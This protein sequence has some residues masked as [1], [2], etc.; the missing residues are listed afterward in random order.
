MKELETLREERAISAHKA[1]YLALG[2]D[3]A[4]AL[5]NAKALHKGDY[6]TVFANQKKFLEAQK[7]AAQAGA[8][9][10]QPGLSKGAS[11]GDGEDGAVSLAKQLGK[12]KS[13]AAKTYNDILKNYVK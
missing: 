4:M 5:E 12:Q 3:E 10:N 6:D 2:Y 7:K 1:S 11:G 9:D 13:S 8:M